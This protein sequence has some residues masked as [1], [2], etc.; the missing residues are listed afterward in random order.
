MQKP[1]AVW[2]SARDVWETP[3]TEGFF[4][5]HLDV[6]SE[7]FPTSGMTAG[8]KLYELP[9]LAHRM[10]DQG[11]S[12]LLPTPHA[13]LGTRGG[14][15]HPEKKKAGGHMVDLGDVA[16]FMLLPTPAASDWKRDDYPA[17][18]LRKSPN[19]TTVSA[20][21][22]NIPLPFSDGSE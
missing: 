15:Q 16:E 7:T 20:Y 8:G 21:F 18:R 6:Y 14:A 17:D 19:I 1:V 2:N 9:T 13:G 4:C 12:S 11:S 3:Q 22:E 5:E 10:E